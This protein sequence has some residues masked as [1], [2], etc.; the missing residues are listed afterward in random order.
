MCYTQE[1]AVSSWNVRNDIR[2]VRLENNAVLKN[3]EYTSVFVCLC[4][5]VFVYLSSH[6]SCEFARCPIIYMTDY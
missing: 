5:F 3:F 4:C 2:D 6:T 1:L